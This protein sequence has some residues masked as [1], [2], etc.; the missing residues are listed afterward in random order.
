MCVCVCF[1]DIAGKQE[2]RRIGNF[3]SNHFHLTQIHCT[4]LAEQNTFISGS[5]I[6][7]PV[8]NCRA[9]SSEWPLKS[10]IFPKSSLWS[11]FLYDAIFSNSS[12]LQFFDELFGEKKQYDRYLSK[13]KISLKQCTHGCLF[14]TR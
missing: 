6:C 13:Q 2:I 5:I 1:L 4:R 3:H 9:F 12:I 8:S 11:C 7:N 14:F 10:S